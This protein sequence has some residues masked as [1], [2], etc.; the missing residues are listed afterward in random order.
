M[1][2][3]SLQAFVEVANSDS[4]SIAAEQL[5]LTQPAVSKRIA[6]LE[7]QLDAK[8]FDRIGRKVHLTEAGQTLLPRARQLLRDMDASQRALHDL[9]GDISGS[10]SIAI[11]HHI[12][13]HRLPPVLRRFTR[14]YPQVRLNIDFMDSEQAHDLILAG[15]L[16]FAVITLAPALE[17][18]LESFEVWPDPLVVMLDHDHALANEKSLSLEQLAEHTALPPGLGT[19]TGQMIKAQFDRAGLSM[20]T[21]M[22]TNYLETI[23]VMVSVGLGWSLLPATLADEQVRCLPLKG[24]HLERQLG[25]VYHKRRSLSNAAGAFIALLREEASLQT[26]A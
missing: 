8:L 20:D 3:Q 19:Y 21:G 12:G 11:S 17:E 9:S 10:L 22:T 25:C 23:K 1:D 6:K 2:R 18:D 15:D 7:E 24:V 5:H 14:A 13:L 4:F 26:E 16:D